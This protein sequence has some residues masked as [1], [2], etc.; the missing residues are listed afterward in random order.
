MS[1][2]STSGAIF[3]SSLKPNGTYFVKVIGTLP[4]LFST[5][6]EIFT[7]NMNTVPVFSN[8]LTDVIVPLMQSVNYPFPSI[9]DPD[10]GSTTFVSVV[11]DSV[12][13]AQPSFIT[14]TSSSIIINPT[15]VT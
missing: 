12:T 6:S 5:Y 7:I 4:D 3:V 10:Y 1:V 11:K 9:I 2:D 15:L 14:F 8:S 13:N